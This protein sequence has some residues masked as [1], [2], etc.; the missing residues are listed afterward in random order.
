MSLHTL[1]KGR[2]IRVGAAELLIQQRLTGDRWQLQNT[3]TGEWCTFSEDDLLD[4]FARN[5]L[6]FHVTADG[7]CSSLID[8]FAE[9]L[10]RDLS[11]YK[12]EVLQLRRWGSGRVSG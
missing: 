7:R 2:H 3:A 8:K 12:P 11:T 6:L 10:S 4:R 9:K 1:R 5:E